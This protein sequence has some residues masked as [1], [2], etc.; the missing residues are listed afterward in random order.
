MRDSSSHKRI[1]I[2]KD[3]KIISV[4][5]HTMGNSHKKNILSTK[6]YFIEYILLPE[7]YPFLAVSNF[8]DSVVWILIYQEGST[9]AR[10]RIFWKITTDNEIDLIGFIQ[11]LVDTRISIEHQTDVI[12]RTNF[13]LPET[14][15]KI[16]DL[17][18][19]TTKLL[20]ILKYLI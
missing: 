14:I 4:L 11:L 9:I 2:Q 19:T 12:I 5:F 7:K 20:N 13:G 6:D 3:I 16:K 17:T 8:S 10:E 18:I 1:K 15:H